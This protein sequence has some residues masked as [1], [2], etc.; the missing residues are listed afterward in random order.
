MIPN[1]A[2]LREADKRFRRMMDEYHDTMRGT[3]PM[4]DTF[5]CESCGAV[6]EKGW[7]DEEAAKECEE[8]FHVRNPKGQLE[9]M[10]VV[11]D[12]CFRLM[13]EWM[14]SGPEHG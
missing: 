2:D 8:I 14:A 6:Y 11:C 10:A 4:A 13:Q 5:T 3:W 1:P 9:S 12:D 7:T